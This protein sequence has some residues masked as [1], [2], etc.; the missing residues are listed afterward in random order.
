MK[1]VFKKQSSKSKLKVQ[2]GAVL[3][4]S[5]TSLTQGNPGNFVEDHPTRPRPNAC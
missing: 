3:S 5:A 4:K 2:K 1:N